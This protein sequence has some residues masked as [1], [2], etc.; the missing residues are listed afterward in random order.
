MK[1]EIKKYEYKKSPFYKLESKKKL[2]TYL[3]KVE[4]Y[5]N[6]KEK[7]DREEEYIEFIN[8]NGRIIE[9]PKFNLKN[10]QK[11]ISKLMLKI[12]IPDYIFSSCKGKDY[13]KNAEHHKDSFYVLIMDISKFFP[14][15]KKNN[16]YYLYKDKFR[17]SPDV[18][19]IMTELTTYKKHLP[20]GAPT[21][22]ILAY[23]SN[24]KMFNELFMYAK[25]NKFKIS[26]YVDDIVFS[27][28]KYFSKIIIKDIRNILEKYNFEC[29]NKKTRYC[30]K[31]EYI[32]ITGVMIKGNGEVKIP[33]SMRKKII[34]Q[35]KIYDCENNIIN[36]KKIGKSLIGQIAS[37]RRIERKFLESTYIKI[38]KEIK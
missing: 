22:M 37:A 7:Y 36:K 23:L 3:F 31:K 20:T 14:S 4:N 12:I 34:E 13:I 11:R 15:C 25:K 1:L 16:V 9:A 32:K 30:N 8:D 28:R 24:E 19:Y 27:S 35:L 29:K 2:A 5:F 18:A 17:M 6:N 10:I 33:N 38:K 26:I 21:S